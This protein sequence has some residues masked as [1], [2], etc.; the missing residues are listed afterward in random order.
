MQASLNLELIS[1][2]ENS[3]LTNICAEIAQAKIHDVPR[4]SAFEAL[5]AFAIDP[6][7]T[8][9]RRRKKDVDWYIYL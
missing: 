8:A 7:S 6:I 1:S 4:P 3:L 9:I 2:G 5:M